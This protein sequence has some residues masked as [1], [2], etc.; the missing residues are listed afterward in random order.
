MSDRIAERKEAILDVFWRRGLG[1]GAI[2]TFGDAELLAA[3]GFGPESPDDHPGREAFRLL[4]S[5]NLV[6]ELANGLRL[7]EDGARALLERPA[8]KYGARVY[9]L[10]GRGALLVKQ[11]VLRGDPPEYAIDEHKERHVREDD[12]RALAAAVRDAVNGRL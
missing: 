4:L 7:T 5:D 9:K 3:M 2:V 8:A 10:A 1:A 6:V 12:D 11:T